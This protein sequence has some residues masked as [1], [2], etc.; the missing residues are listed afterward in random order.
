MRVLAGGTVKHKR[1]IERMQS[2]ATF[3]KREHGCGRE[4]AHNPEP[5]QAGSVNDGSDGSVT[6]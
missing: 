4:R 5:A 3:P 1:P 6:S 2:R